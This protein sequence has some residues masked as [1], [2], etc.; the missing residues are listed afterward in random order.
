M[1]NVSP[2]ISQAI[3]HIAK[4]VE[5][6]APEDKHALVQKEVTK[7][8]EDFAKAIDAHIDAKLKS[9]ESNMARGLETRLRM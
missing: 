7:Y 2:Q 4:V 5:D 3:K 1:P 9:F 8:L 6:L